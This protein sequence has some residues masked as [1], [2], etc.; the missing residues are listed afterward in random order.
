M[1][2]RR[3][4][5]IWRDHIL[6]RLVTKFVRLAISQPA[7]N[8]SPGHPNAETLAVVITP[9]SIRTTMFLGYWQPTDLTSPMNQ[10]GIEQAPL[11]EIRY[12][13]RSGFVGLATYRR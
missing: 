10:R 5:I 4:E 9:S 3:L 12:Q 7:S 6:D 11:L 8:P 2:H 1:H 13:T